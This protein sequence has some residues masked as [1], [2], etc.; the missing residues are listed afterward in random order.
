MLI[1]IFTVIG[2]VGAVGKSLQ[3][4]RMNPDDQTASYFKYQE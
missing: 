2:L 3:G 4:T 1:P